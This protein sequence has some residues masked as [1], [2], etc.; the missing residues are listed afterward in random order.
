MLYFKLSNKKCKCGNN[1][2]FFRYKGKHIGAYCSMCGRWLK[3]CD[4]DERNI[5]KLFFD[6]FKK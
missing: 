2:F 4:E 5:A 1:K 6:Q 3:W